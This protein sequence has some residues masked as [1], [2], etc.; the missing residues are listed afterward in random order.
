MAAGRVAVYSGSFSGFDTNRII[1]TGGYGGTYGEPGGDGTIRLLRLGQITPQLT[2]KSV[3]GQTLLSW[4]G[5]SGIQYQLL[6]S[7]TLAAPAWITL[8]DPL[9]GRGG[10]LSTNVPVTS[11]PERYFRLQVLNE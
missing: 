1:V 7:A 8:G 10:Q 4:P 9:T 3:N 6:S 2:L 11:E 5:F